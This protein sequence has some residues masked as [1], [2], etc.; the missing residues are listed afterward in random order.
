MVYIAQQSFGFGEVDP[1]I[2]AQYESAPYQRGCQTLENAFL[3]DTGSALKR[4]GSVTLTTDSGQYRAFEFINGHGERYLIAND[5]NSA[6]NTSQY[7]II[8][9]GTVISTYTNS[10]TTTAEYLKDVASDGYECF[11]LTTDGPFV[12]KLV[13]VGDSRTRLD[14]LKFDLANSVPD[15]TMQ[16]TDSDMSGES[17]YNE[18]IIVTPNAYFDLADKGDLY[19]MCPSASPAT[20]LEPRF[21]ALKSNNYRGTEASHASPE[22]PFKSSTQYYVRTVV[23]RT[24]TLKHGLTVSAPGGTSTFPLTSSDAR[25]TDDADGLGA[26]LKARVYWNG[27]TSLHT[28]DGA[29]TAWKDQNGNNAVTDGGYIGVEFTS[30]G[31]L[32]RLCV[33]GHTD[34]TPNTGF[35]YDI[36]G[37]S[38]FKYL[39]DFGFGIQSDSYGEWFHRKV[40]ASATQYT[41]L[42]LDTD[43]TDW[44]GP[45]RNWKQI[46]KPLYTGTSGVTNVIDSATWTQTYVELDNV[47]TLG[48]ISSSFDSDHKKALTCGAV[49]KFDHY[50][51]STLYNTT[52]FYVSDKQFEPAD[53]GS[54][55]KIILCWGGNVYSPTGDATFARDVGSVEQTLVMCLAS[56]SDEEADGL[57][58]QKLS[59][60]DTLVRRRTN[61]IDRV[62]LVGD[63]R[64]QVTINSYVP[65]W[66]DSGVIT[67]VSTVAQKVNLTTTVGD[68]NPQENSQVFRVSTHEYSST[69]NYP[70]TAT[71]GQP[72]SQYWKLTG[73]AFNPIPKEGT[74]TTSLIWADN[75]EYH[76][77]RLFFA[78]FVTA[79]ALQ[80][81]RASQAL[82]LTIVSSKSGNTR[83]FTT[84]ANDADGLSFVVVSK[85]GG[86]IQWVKSVFN[87]LFV[88]TESEEFVISDVP[89]TP[90]SINVSL[91][92]SYGARKDSQAIIFDSSIAY[93]SRDGKAINLLD[94]NERA[95]RFES[96][97]IL[98]FAKHLVKTDKV[99]R[100]AVIHEGTPILFALT[101]NGKLHCFTSKPKNNVYGW[102]Q[103]SST[104]LGNFNDIVGTADSSGNPALYARVAGLNSGRGSV[105]ITTDH[106]RLDYLVDNAYEVT[107]S[108]ETPNSA[109]VPA[110]ANQT[111]SVV[112][113]KTD[114]TVVYLGDFTA[115][116]SGQVTFSQVENASKLILGYPFTMKMAPNIPEV[117]VPGKGSTVGREKNISRL[118]V[119][120]NQARGAVAAGYDVMPVPKQTIHANVVDAPGFYS[121]PV[122]GAYGPQPTIY[123]QQSTPYGFEVSGYNAEYDFGD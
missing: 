85:H 32:F 122:V 33:W 6:G 37:T 42:I 92:S 102:S 24:I 56:S 17:E 31:V 100:I 114:G 94:Y 36:Q 109:T 113:K 90:T 20:Q 65:T 41:S 118:R 23:D 116:G 10:Y 74:S 40:D 88:G 34:S 35:Y 50:V 51:G 68:L 71:D 54:D 12:H 5:I 4:W 44:S 73:Q 38:S 47:K 77:Q 27:A 62:G 64:S 53:N 79:T 13:G 55:P 82:G 87:K 84:G 26:I 120:F 48:E 75:I 28:G 45:Y 8:K 93:I 115:N 123:I 96:S 81:L 97:N 117:M 18:K 2:R 30:G 14:N 22:Y 72:G 61:N 119:L 16:I 19:K 111:V 67:S 83:D 21:L 66:N 106:D 95:N 39:F 15:T 60:K 9:D 80:G 89:M 76:Q 101:D 103:W 86:S 107:P 98:Q 104:S 11:V 43:I 59:N 110:F 58:A 99:K 108:S 3:S 49:G 63:P 57:P 121:I 105:L 1:N 46:G 70:N 52:Y 69:T 7:K 91:Q 25:R 29:G 112:L 78:G